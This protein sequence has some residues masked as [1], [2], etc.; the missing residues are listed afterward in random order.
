MNDEVT[1]TDD[2]IITGNLTVNGTT[3]TINTTN[4]DVDDTMIMLANGTTGSPANDIGILFNR[5]AQV[6]RFPMMN[7]LKHLNFQIQKILS[8]IHHSPL[9]PLQI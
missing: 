1:M 8:L 7:Q 2:L 6:R 4:M 9:S 3:T 5:G